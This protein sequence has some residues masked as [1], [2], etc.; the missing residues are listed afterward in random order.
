MSVLL[1]QGWHH[2]YS[3][4]DVMKA[5]DMHHNLQHLGRGWLCFDSGG[6][7]CVGVGIFAFRKVQTVCLPGPQSKSP[8]QIARSGIESSHDPGPWHQ[9][10]LL[11]ACMRY[12]LADLQLWCGCCYQNLTPDVSHIRADLGSVVPAI[13]FLI[14][15]FFW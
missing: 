6:L 12:Y 3:S 11:P 10:S 15:F 9:E 1:H 14:S 2:I 13:R 8:H 4:G 7:F 5:G